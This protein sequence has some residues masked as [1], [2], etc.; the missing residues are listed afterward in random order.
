MTSTTAS[1]TMP[2]NENSS[3]RSPRFWGLP[4]G[5]SGGGGTTCRGAGGVSAGDG[6]VAEMIRVN[7]LGPENTGGAVGTA[8]GAGGPLGGGEAPPTRRSKYES[9]VAEPAGAL[10][11]PQSMDDGGAVGGNGDGTD[12]AGGGAAATPNNR[13]YSPGPAAGGAAC[14]G[15]AEKP[16]QPEPNVGSSGGADGRAGAGGGAGSGSGGVSVVGIGAPNMRVN[17]PGCWAG[18][19]YAGMSCAGRLDCA[20]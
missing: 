12:T 1:S 10:G 14:G 18:G 6:G 11:D 7:S 19:A 5:I 15:G 4:T 13:V 2:T 3:T 9:P 20:G 8:C 17:S 16:D